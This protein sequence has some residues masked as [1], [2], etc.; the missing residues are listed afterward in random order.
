MLSRLPGTTTQLCM[1][2]WLCT[3]TIKVKKQIIAANLQASGIRNGTT[4]KL[5]R[6]YQT[7]NFDIIVI[8]F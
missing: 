1:G 3:C 5:T 4:G 8:T 2:D 7:F 6:I